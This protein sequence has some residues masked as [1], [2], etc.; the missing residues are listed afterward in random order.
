[1]TNQGTHADYFLKDSIVDFQA[2]LSKIEKRSEKLTSDF[3]RVCGFIGMTFTVEAILTRSYGVL[4]VEVLAVFALLLPIYLNRVGAH[5]LAKFQYLLTLNAVVFFFSNLFGQDANIHYN[6][7]PLVGVPWVLIGR[8]E[9]IVQATLWSLLSVVLYSI[10]EIRGFTPLV[11][12]A[13]AHLLHVPSPWIG[14]MSAYFFA[15]VCSWLL[16]RANQADKS[17]LKKVIELYD[18]AKRQTDLLLDSTEEG[19]FGIDLK[20]VCIFANHSSAKLLGY[21]SA[22]DMIGVQMKK[23]F[24][25][26][27]TR[28]SD[29]GS[30]TEFKQV[31]GSKFLASFRAHPMQEDD[32]V[33]GSVVT[34]L[35]ITSQAKAEESIRQ[36]EAMVLASS[37]LASLGEMAGGIAHEINNPLGAISLLAG[38]LN[39]LL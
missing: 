8:R 20:C 18:R 6:F 3:S 11:D 9:K 12:F 38:H 24:S 5:R 4:A 35:D 27:G 13:D 26:W 17:D 28:G 33:I 16:T 32:K 21:S 31:N 39:R 10:T 19:I 14:A 30:K 29:Q 7:L 34:F 15:F 36:Q 37:K 1:M 22:A 23:H 25:S 2:H